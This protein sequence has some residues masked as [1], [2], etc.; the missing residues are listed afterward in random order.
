MQEAVEEMFAGFTADRKT[1]GDVGAGVQP[2]LDSVA[3]GHIFVLNFFTD[4][5]AFAIVSSG[6]G[7]GVGEIIVEND[8][9][10]V[11]T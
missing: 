5:D 1:A 7:A 8:G 2:A 11:G 6:G 9:A 4:G 10:L 3:D